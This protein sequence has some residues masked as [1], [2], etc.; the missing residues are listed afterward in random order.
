MN[1]K[2]SGIS[3]QVVLIVDRLKFL[4]DMYP[5]AITHAG[6]YGKTQ[7][8]K[9]PEHTGL[10][11]RTNIASIFLINNHHDHFR[12]FYCWS[13]LK[14]EVIKQLIALLTQKWCFCLVNSWYN[15]LARHDQMCLMGLSFQRYFSNFENGRSI[16]RIVASLNIFFHDMKK[17]ILPL[18][19]KKRTLSWTK[20]LLLCNLLC[21]TILRWAIKNWFANFMKFRKKR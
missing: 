17:I 21:K 4:R 19:A 1:T 2:H 5:N 10:T 9:P 3:H 8:N 14:R 6:V 12:F 20:R 13:A 16:S 11:G 7:K 15:R 18:N